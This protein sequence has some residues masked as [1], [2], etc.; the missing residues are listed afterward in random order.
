MLYIWPFFAFFSAPLFVPEA[1]H[2]WKRVTLRF[3]PETPQQR[4][5]NEPAG[6]KA[7]QST[8]RTRMKRAIA[9]LVYGKSRYVPLLAVSA[10]A[11]ALLIVHYNTIVHPF[12]LADNR[13][14]MFYV[15]RY[16]IRPSAILR[17]GLVVPYAVSFWFVW[18]TLRGCVTPSYDQGWSLYCPGATVISERT[19]AGTW[20]HLCSPL[21]SSGDVRKI[22][23]GGLPTSLGLEQRPNDS[24][25][26]SSEQVVTTGGQQPTQGEA[27]RRHVGSR[28]RD[29]D[30]EPQPDGSTTQTAAGSTATPRPTSQ[31]ATPQSYQGQQQIGPQPRRQ[32]ARLGGRFATSHIPPAT[33]TVALW[34]LTTT[35][36]LCTAP[37]VEP[38][39][40]ILPWIFFRLLVPSWSAHICPISP[41][42]AVRKAIIATR[43]A[44]A[45]RRREFSDTRRA[46]L[47]AARDAA[48]RSDATN[49]AQEAAA[50]LTDFDEPRAALRDLDKSSAEP[51]R[52][53]ING[54]GLDRGNCQRSTGGDGGGGPGVGDSGGMRAALLTWSKT[55]LSAAA[56]DVVDI[57]LVLEALWF[58]AVNAVVGWVFLYRPYV[59]RDQQGEVLDDGRLQRFMW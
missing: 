56:Y 21:V 44:V 8:L 54:E 17:H 47:V 34:L 15:F 3:R 37:L 1:V 25:P 28:T 58:L 35:L 51:T 31:V 22:W 42:E 7:A 55:L 11:A 45:R 52:Q 10:L 13:H 5:G 9:S 36:S 6:A 16:L 14:Y 38:R 33:S 18:S 32:F 50:A 46:A 48:E 23:F 20:L 4:P 30:T 29:E 19:D 26:S 39:Y 2:I 57:R 24:S 40:F 53:M 12:L 41:A 27:R 59:W 43:D 49:Q